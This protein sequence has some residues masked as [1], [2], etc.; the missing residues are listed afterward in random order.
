M[1][2]RILS[3]KF[4]QIRSFNNYLVSVAARWPSFFPTLRSKGFAYYC[5]RIRAIGTLIS[6]ELPIPIMEKDLS[7]SFG[8]LYQALFGFK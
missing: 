7:I 3:L 4:E 8:F 2:T 6:L 1:S 5:G